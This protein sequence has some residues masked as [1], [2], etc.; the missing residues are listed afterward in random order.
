MDTR[1]RQP[2]D[3]EQFALETIEAVESVVSHR[4]LDAGREPTPDLELMLSGGRTVAVEITMSTDGA[5]RS[6]CESLDGRRWPRAELACEWW[7]ILSDYSREA[8]GRRR[9]IKALL[10]HLVVAVGV[11]VVGGE[12]FEGFGSVGTR[13]AVARSLV[14]ANS[15]VS[16]SWRVR[17]RSAWVAVRKTRWCLEEVLHGPRLSIH[18]EVRGHLGLQVGQER[19]GSPS[20][21]SR[22]AS[23]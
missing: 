23:R 14:W 16:R 10:G 17:R 19:D 11:G 18:F 22:W 4:W 9:N 15:A 3:E 13:M 21:S 8:R 20:A 5:A 6:L 1:S 12:A 7:V 2:R